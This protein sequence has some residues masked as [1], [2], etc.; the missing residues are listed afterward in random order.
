MFINHPILK[1]RILKTVGG[2]KSDFFFTPPEVFKSHI[3]N[4]MIQ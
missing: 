2:E 1:Y 3:L 4:R